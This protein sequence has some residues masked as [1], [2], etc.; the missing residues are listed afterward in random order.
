M[1]LHLFRHIQKNDNHVLELLSG[2]NNELF[3][4]YFKQGIL[5]LVESQL[6]LF[7]P[8]KRDKLP[9]S[10]WVDHIASTFAGTIRWWVEHGKHESPET[11]TEYF[12]SAL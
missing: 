1:F 4:R 2:S 8:V 9:E 12:F 10:Y 11:L 6:S 3:L 7:D 5:E